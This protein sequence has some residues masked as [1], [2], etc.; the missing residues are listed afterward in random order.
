MSVFVSDVEKEIFEEVVDGF[1]KAELC[2]PC[3]VRHHEFP[4]F[5]PAYQT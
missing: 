2:L 4:H 3:R 1:V 5:R